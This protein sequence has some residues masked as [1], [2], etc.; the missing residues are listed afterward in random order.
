MIIKH[1]DEFKN[2]IAEPIASQQPFPNTLES[3]IESA[4]ASANETFKL[5]M[6]EKLDYNDLKERPGNN[7]KL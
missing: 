7:A 3:P 4:T 2:K 1:D 6:P 5:A